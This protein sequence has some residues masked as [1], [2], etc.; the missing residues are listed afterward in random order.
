MLFYLDQNIWIDLARI[1]HGK[2]KSTG[3]ADLFEVIKFNVEKGSIKLPLSGVHYM[4]T[5]T[6]SNAGRRNRLGQAMFELSGGL[7][8]ASYRKIVR[9]EIETAISGFFSNV[10]PR[11]FSLLGYG[12]AHACEVDMPLHMPG[13]LRNLV[14]RSCLTGE[15]LFGGSMPGFQK[16]SHGTNF[17]NHLRDLK[18]IRAQLPESRWIDALN[19]MSLMD[20]HDSLCEVLEFWGIDFDDFISLGPE[21]LDSIISSM[22]S[23]VLDR[24]LHLQ[25]LRNPNYAPKATDLE[26]WAGVALASQYCDVVIAEKHMADMLKREGFKKSNAVFSRL[27]DIKGLL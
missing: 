1:F 15:E 5:A 14:E 23:R 7:A 17:T 3:A 21:K 8:I 22:P 25:V 2:D 19:A 13:N 9:H 16:G 10:I 6:I 4:E 18:Q 12:V 27:S 11:E 26:D 20:I 24:H